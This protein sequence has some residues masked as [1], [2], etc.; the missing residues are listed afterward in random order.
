[1]VDQFKV[2]L[3]PLTSELGLAVRVTVGAG[4]LG[5]T[6][7]VAAWVALPPGPLQVRV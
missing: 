1:M 4:V 6:A 3:L 7:T 5:V 2:E